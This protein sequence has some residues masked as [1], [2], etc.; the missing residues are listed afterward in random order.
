MHI[1]IYVV[2]MTG[3]VTSYDARIL[4][5]VPYPVFDMY[6]LRSKKT[7]NYE[8]RAGQTISTLTKFITKSINFYV[9]KQFYYKN[10]FHN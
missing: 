7:Y 8:K 5:E 9:S 10:I 1:R 3:G 2:E 6:S 4:Q